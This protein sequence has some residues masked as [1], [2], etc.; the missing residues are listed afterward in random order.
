MGSSLQ[1]LPHDHP[2]RRE[3][4]RI[5][6]ALTNDCNRACPFC[7]VYS[8][9]GK[10]TYLGLPRFLGLLPTSGQFEA[11]FE[12]G[13]PTLHSQL[14]EFIVLSRAT[15]RC[16]RVIVCTNGV[17]LPPDTVRLLS[18]IR[19]WMGGPLTIKLSVNHHLAQTDRHWLRRAKSLVRVGQDHGVDVVLN[20]RRRPYG[21]RDVGLLDALR[22]EGLAA[23]T[24]DFW[25]QRYG[26]ASEDQRLEL[27]YLAGT[28]F[29]LVNP[30][31]SAHETDLLARSEAMRALP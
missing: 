22:D 25:L 9:P 24:N 3:A 1:S 18:R 20:L 30:D 31:G 2:A 7:S 6:F 4:K 5:Y 29:E 15:L 11:Q 21:T 27:P 8:A 13:E 26:L 17:R 10:T 28:N 19:P 23:F 14:D 16:E 12:G